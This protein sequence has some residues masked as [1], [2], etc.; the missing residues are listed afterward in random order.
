MSEPLNHA[1]NTYP[2]FSKDKQ[3]ALF[4]PLIF[5]S[6]YYSAISYLIYLFL[7]GALGQ[8]LAHNGVPSI[9]WTPKDDLRLDRRFVRL[10]PEHK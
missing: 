7:S 8:C 9:L 1:C 10:N 2:N 6:L 3:T 5:R 4:N